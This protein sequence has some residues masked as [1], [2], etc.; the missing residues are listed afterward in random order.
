MK[1]IENAKKESEELQSMINNIGKD[2]SKKEEHI[3]SKET[4]VVK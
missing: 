4:N 2:I 3:D 1:S